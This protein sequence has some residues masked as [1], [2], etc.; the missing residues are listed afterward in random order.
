MDL[1]FRVPQL[2]AGQIEELISALGGA[3]MVTPQQVLLVQRVAWAHR[4]LQEMEAQY[5]VG[6]GLDTPEWTTLTTTLVSCLRLLGLHR[7]AKP[8]ESLHQYMA[9]KSALPAPS[10]EGDGT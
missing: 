5:A 10:T 6:Q 9:R 1:R 7:R 8:V 3:D 2:I 4:R